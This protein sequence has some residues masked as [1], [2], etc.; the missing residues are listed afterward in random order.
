MESDLYYIQDG[1][2]ITLVSNTPE[3]DYIYNEIASAFN[4]VAKFPVSM[5]ES[6]LHQIKQAGYSIRKA[7]TSETKL[8][9]ELASSMLAELGI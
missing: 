2:Y 3:G 5:K 9:P 6:I 4:G 7:R 1:Y 8:T